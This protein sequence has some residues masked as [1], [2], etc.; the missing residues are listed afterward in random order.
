M[1]KLTALCAS[2]LLLFAWTVHADTGAE[3][4][5]Q[6]PM[7]D[8]QT[9]SQDTL[10]GYGSGVERETWGTES[11][12]QQNATGKQKEMKESSNQQMD[13]SQQP[14]SETLG[15]YGSG[16]ERKSYG[17][18]GTAE[19]GQQDVEGEVRTYKQPV[20]EQQEPTQDTLGG[21]GSGIERETYGAEGTSDS[22]FKDKNQPGE[23]EKSRNMQDTP[24][25]ETLGGYGS[26]GLTEHGQG[27]ESRKSDIEE[28]TRTYKQPVEEEE[29]PTQDTLG[30]FG[31]GV[32]RETYG[33]EE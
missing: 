31:S 4:Y 15:G 12:R 26:G 8:Q 11:D 16:V 23:S 3:T 20:E 17:A 19:S 13:S 22:G 30:G 14:G 33:A 25:S 28:E 6:Q 27:G 18:E 1:R 24:G 9:P 21:F 7:E 29:A 10:G 5:K 2:T 32:E